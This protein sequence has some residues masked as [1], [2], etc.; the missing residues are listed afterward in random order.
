MAATTGWTSRACAR[1]LYVNVPDMLGL[2]LVQLLRPASIRPYLLTYSVM[3]R[4]AH[5]TNETKT[6]G[7]P[8]FAPH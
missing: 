5:S 7:L 1:S 3:M 8:N 2:G 6:A 4:S